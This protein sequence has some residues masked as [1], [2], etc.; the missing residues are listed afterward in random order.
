MARRFRI[1]IDG[2]VYHAAMQDNPLVNRL[3]SLCPFEQEYT[4][5]TENEYYTK[6]VEECSDKGCQMIS[7]AKKNTICFFKGWNAL[8]FVFYDC[9]I[10]PFKI[11]YLGD[12]E[13]DATEQLR[14]AEK[15]IRVL[16]EDITETA[17]GAERE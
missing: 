5:N 16:C 10:A 7:K 15:T 6:L 1:T 8:N 12:M 17:G 13:E 4:R 3:A 11:A 9:D 2:T 14:K